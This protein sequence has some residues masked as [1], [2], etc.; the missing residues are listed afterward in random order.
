[1][2]QDNDKQEA[3]E[4]DPQVSA[5][6]ESLAEEKTPAD[7]DRAI[8]REAARA[9]RTDNRKGSFGAWFRPV[10]FMATVGL[11][12]VIIL[13]LSDTSLFSPPADM[14]LEA[15]PPTPVQ[16]PAQSAA[17]ATGKTRSQA[18][19][20]KFMRQ[21]KSETAQS[22]TADAPETTGDDAGVAPPQAKASKPSQVDQGRLLQVPADDAA[23]ETQ[24]I[25]ELLEDHAA[26]SEAFATEVENALA[27]SRKMARSR[28]AGVS[29]LRIAC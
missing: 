19:E 1:M 3:M 5:H 29:T 11:S 2:N 4:V 21:E 18:K 20:S 6:Y 22:L 27:A 16:A 10:A 17:D 26:V 24:P 13:D 28:S 8:L 15:V 14:S 12:L 23:A 25:E 9:L 7:L